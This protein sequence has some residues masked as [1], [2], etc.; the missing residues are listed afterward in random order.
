MSSLVLFFVCLFFFFVFVVR[1]VYWPVNYH[2]FSSFAQKWLCVAHIDRTT[3]LR[4]VIANCNVNCLFLATFRFQW[5]WRLSKFLFL[6]NTFLWFFFSFKWE[7]FTQW[8]EHVFVIAMRKSHWDKQFNNFVFSCCFIVR[9]QIFITKKET[10]YR[11]QRVHKA[12]TVFVS[13][14]FNEILL[15]LE[16]K[17][18]QKWK[19]SSVLI[20]LNS[21][22]FCLKISLS[23]FLLFRFSDKTILFCYE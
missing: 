7:S 23:I 20:Q 21:K 8:N 15:Y 14:D 22:R 3:H 1:I 17:I 2:I 18:K 13:R 11:Q 5:L 16:S 10:I 4:F 19:I 12:C 9:S 6:S